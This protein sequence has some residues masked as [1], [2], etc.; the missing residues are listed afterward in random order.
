MNRAELISL[1]T[2]LDSSGTGLPFVQS[3]HDGRSGIALDAG[4]VR[5]LISRAYDEVVW[6][7]V[8]V[9]F[10]C[11]AVVEIGVVILAMKGHP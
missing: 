5:D 9:G 8:A 3:E 11:A 10:A 6:R 7:W 1:A 2:L 4:L